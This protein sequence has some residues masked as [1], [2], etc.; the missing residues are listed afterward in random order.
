MSSNGNRVKEGKSK[1]KSRTERAGIQFPVGRVHRQLR[2]AVNESISG[3]A[4]V[5]LAAVLEYLVAELLEMASNAAQ[6]NRKKRIIP[7]H[8][9]MA[10]YNDEEMHKLLPHV[11]ISQGGPFAYNYPTDEINQ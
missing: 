7:R 3:G 11:I 6:D 4:P 1:G 2:K 10:I 5:Y 9:T 8:V